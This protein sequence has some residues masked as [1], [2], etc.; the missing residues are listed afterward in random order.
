MIP[1]KGV[2][3][4]MVRRSRGRMELAHSHTLCYSL[5]AQSRRS[6]GNMGG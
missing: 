4:A 3:V 1:L 2:F 5:A 6:A